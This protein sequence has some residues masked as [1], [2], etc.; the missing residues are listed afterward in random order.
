MVQLSL[1]FQQ[2]RRNMRRDELIER[3]KYAYAYPYA[4]PYP[5]PYPYPYPY[6]YPSGYVCVY[7][8]RYASHPAHVHILTF[9]GH[10]HVF[11]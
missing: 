2:A 6:P 5:D 10:L 4:Y 11:M 3:P 8:Y 7:V 9:P 1:H